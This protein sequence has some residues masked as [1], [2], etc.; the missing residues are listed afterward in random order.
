MMSLLSPLRLLIQNLLL[1]K[2]NK[3]SD[4]CLLV[5]SQI[6]VGFLKGMLLMILKAT[7]IE[8]EAALLVE[9]STL[10]IIISFVLVFISFNAFFP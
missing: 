2:I 7:S 9:S 6:D 5:I 10:F 4:S 8:I 1:A 3:M